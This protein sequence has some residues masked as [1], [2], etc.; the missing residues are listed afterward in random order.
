MDALV[1][2]VRTA[3]ICL[4]AAG[5]KHQLF[6][7]CFTIGK[8]GEMLT[9]ITQCRWFHYWADNLS[10]PEKVSLEA[11]FKQEGKA[12]GQQRQCTLAESHQAA[13]GPEPA[14]ENS[15]YERIVKLG[16]E[17]RRRKKRSLS[18]HNTEAVALHKL[19]AQSRPK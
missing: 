14:L 9:K 1:L 6:A 10:R 19:E 17:A 8:L 18:S 12:A 4:K 5:V 15:A 3:K 7:D 2:A 11:W 13:Q 16:T